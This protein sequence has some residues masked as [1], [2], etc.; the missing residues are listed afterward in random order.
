VPPLFGSDPFQQ[1]HP[2]PLHWHRRLYDTIHGCRR[3]NDQV[4]LLFLFFFSGAYCVWC[5]QIFEV[6]VFVKKICRSH[7]TKFFHDVGWA[8]CEDCVIAMMVDRGEIGH[9]VLEKCCVTDP[10]VDLRTSEGIDGSGPY[11]KTLVNGSTEHFSL[12]KD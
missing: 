1:A 5:T 4:L 3:H 7:V 11:I 10:N 6:N 12:S 2:R 8:V 9:K